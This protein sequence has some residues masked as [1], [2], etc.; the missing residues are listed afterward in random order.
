M[1]AKF[2][3][4]LKSD[5][6]LPRLR[7]GLIGEGRLIP[8]ADGEVRL[9]Y[10]DYAASGRAL[11]QVENF[12]SEEI[13]PF[14]ANSHTET[15]YCGAVMNKR[16]A[17]ARAEI[18]RIC[19]ADDE[20]FA[21]I[22]TGSGAT[23]AA[24]KTAQLILGVD[25]A[26]KPRRNFLSFMGRN[27]AR[28]KATRPLVIIGP[29]EHH[30]NILPWRESGAKVIEISE[31]PNGGPDLNTLEAVLRENAG[32][33]KIIGAFSA[34][35]NV[36]GICTDIVAVTRLLK[37]YGARAVWDYAAAAP[38][39][40]VTMTPAEDAP[41]DAIFIS[42]H[43]YIGGPGASGV[44]IFRKEAATIARPTQPGGGT[45][46]FVSPTGHRYL[47]DLVAREE[48]GTPN[49]V[50]DIRAAL[51]MM[52]KNAVSDEFVLARDK[53]FASRA[54]K[55]WKA[56]PLLEILGNCE[57]RRLPVFSVRVRDGKGGY[58]HH[59]LFTRMLSDYY[60]VQ[61]RG[62]CV[63]AGPYGHRLLGIDDAESQRLLKLIEAGYEDEKPGWVRVNFSWLMT[64]EDAEF[65]INAV[66]EL[67]HRAPEL[68][69][70]YDNNP[71]TARFTI[72]A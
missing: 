32:K 22:F 72:A 69:E 57:A 21:V 12:I 9:R 1:L 55:A 26:E 68:A 31:A 6:L 11:S 36:T 8:G 54:M 56:E 25:G 41:I 10:A 33:R 60:G 35:S 17:E 40:P 2:A 29:Y 47:P 53:E 52:V 45:V 24:N 62:G 27:S 28:A 20:R 30:S 7:D 58:V 43:K 59:L 44:L 51:A 23:A 4:E 48:A 13:L 46:L 39:L 66:A 67:A 16:R 71:A 37:K 14:Y 3:D 65:L 49:I 5:G 34:A 50:G 19:G 18:A 64:D 15:S 38:Y 63:C 70:R 42:P 61:A